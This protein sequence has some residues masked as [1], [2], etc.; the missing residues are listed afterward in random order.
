MSIF[1]NILLKILT[2]TVT[3]KLVAAGVSKLLDSTNSGIKKD[4]AKTMINGIV[5]SKQNSVTKTDAFKI[6]KSL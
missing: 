2:S 5:L 3:E 6:L 4:L 1:V